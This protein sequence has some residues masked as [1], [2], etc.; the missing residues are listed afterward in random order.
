ME[1]LRPRLATLAAA[2]LLAAHAAL[3]LHAATWQSTVYDEPYYASAGYARLAG[4]SLA[5]NPEHPP[6]MKLLLGAAWLGADLPPPAAVEGFAQGDQWTFG[7]RLLYRDPARAP[8]LLLRARAVVAAVSVLLGLGVF[9]VARRVGGAAAGLLA[10]ALY[11]FDPLV[12]ANAGLATLDLGAAAAI[13]AAVVLAER[14][15]ERGTPGWIAAAGLATGAALGVKATG[16]LVGPAVIALALAPLLAPV[17]PGWRAVGIRLGRGAVVG[18]LGVGVLALLSWPEGLA[19]WWGAFELQRHHAQVGHM[20]FLL[21]RYSNV[22]F[23]WYYPVGWLVK[24]PVPVLLATAGGALLVLRE[25]RREPTRAALLLA[26]PAGLLAVAMSSRICNGVRNLLPMTPFLAVAAGV[27]LARLR[28]PGWRGLAALAAPAWTAA[29]LL[30]VHPHPL[31]YANALAGG[32]RGAWRHVTDSNLDWGQGIP[33]LAEALEGVPLRRLWLDHFGLALPAAH[34]L[35][36]YRLVHDAGFRAAAVLRHPRRDGPDPAGRELLAVSATSLVDV[37]V[38]DKQLH[39]WLRART[40]WR[41][42]GNS[43]AIYDVTSDLEAHRRLAAMAEAK[44]D[45]LTAREAEARVA[46]LEAG[47]P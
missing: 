29:A 23:W 46:E 43:I 1:P 15:V 10:L 32:P 27:A 14:A 13:F 30:L 39:A 44:G 17:R 37:Y 20:T 18:A 25:L 5:L 21:G 6:V 12:V 38:R 41:W 36:R 22:G 28:G 35:P 40:P 2:A 3:V 4:G 34:G 16:L 24:T 45:P 31:T 33:A 47:E 9:L 26:L 11:A 42:A 19:P 8:G 7:P